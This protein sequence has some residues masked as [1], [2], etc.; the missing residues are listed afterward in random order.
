MAEETK[1]AVWFYT[2]FAMW[3]GV[4]FLVWGATGVLALLGTFALVEGIVRY[5]KLPRRRGDGD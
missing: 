1:A 2:G 4:C 3:T 5:A